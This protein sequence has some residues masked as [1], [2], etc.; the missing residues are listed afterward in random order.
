[1]PIH[2][3]AVIGSG[4][5]GAGIAQVM[6]QGGKKVLL[7]DI[8]EE[9]IQKGKERI[10]DHLA[11]SVKKGRIT[12]AERGGVLENI[13]V[14]ADIEATASADFVIEAATEDPNIK[15]RIFRQ[16]D[17]LAGQKA[18]LASNTSSI[19]ITEIASV[20]RRS[21]QVIGMHFFNPVPVMKLVEV[22]RGLDTSEKTLQTTLHLAE[23]LGKVPVKINDFPGFAANRILLPMINEA[24][25]CVYEGV[26]GA[27]E[28]DQVMRLGA[29]H[30]M[31]PLALA[32][33]I[34]LDTCLSIMEV[35]Y[36]G[37]GDPKYRPCPLLRKYVQAGWLGRKTGRG[38][39]HYEKG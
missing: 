16:L 2:T 28:I 6:A 4:Q 30:P 9:R 21:G 15:K 26:S 3:V 8:T 36:Q 22:V 34:G 5:M 13:H 24:V 31:G 25:Y 11:R 14:A 27:E 37:Y 12:E 1:M 23:A 33:L 20:T 7:N 29:N 32:D 35:L 38:F 10:A 39:Y 18:I 17:Q 19:A